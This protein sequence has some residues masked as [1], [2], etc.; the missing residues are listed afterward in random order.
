MKKIWD[1]VSII[2]VANTL[3]TAVLLVM[4]AG[5]GKLSGENIRRIRLVLSGQPIEPASSTTAPDAKVDAATSSGQ[6]ITRDQTRTQAMQLQIDQQM[7][8]LKNFQMQ[9]DQARAALDAQMA[10]FDRQR[11]DW[12]SRRKADDE[13][14]ASEGFRKSLALYESMSPDQA[15]D[16][17]MTMGDAEVIRLMKAMD[18]RKSSKIAKA[19][20][21]DAEKARL[22]KILDQMEKPGDAM[23][24]SGKPDQ[25]KANP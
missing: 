15:K 24:T 11:E 13:L 7:R 2:A 4:M 10:Q 18:E 1:I 19:F 14:L 20:V 16:L 3:A 9:V 25:G 6:M 12:E 21:A 17:F 22:R 23:A 8:E 5:S